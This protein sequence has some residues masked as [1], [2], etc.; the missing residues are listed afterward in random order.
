MAAEGING[1]IVIPFAV[2]AV[3]QSGSFLLKGS[4][5]ASELVQRPESGVR[6][7]DDVA[8]AIASGAA[9]VNVHSQ[10]NPGGEIRGQLCPTSALANTF[11]GV[12]LCTL[13]ARGQ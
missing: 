1:P 3:G 8:F 12:A 4:A 6:V 10:A 5:R 9:Y 13:P 2:A 7:W 11:N